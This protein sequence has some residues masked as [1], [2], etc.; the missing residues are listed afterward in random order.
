[1]KFPITREALQ[2][3][4][5]VEQER[6]ADEIR[7]KNHIS[8]LVSQI[9]SNIKW[10][11]EWIMPKPGKLRISDAETVQIAHEKIMREKRYIWHGLENIRPGNQF[12]IPG[13]DTRQFMHLSDADLIELLIQKLKETFIGCDIIVDRN[14]SIIIDW[15]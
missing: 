13:I 2:R 11:M 3:F 6:L 4:D 10:H 8:D 5:P 14:N 9:C 1:M 12:I 15:S 7:L